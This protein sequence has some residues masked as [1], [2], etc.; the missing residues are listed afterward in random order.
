[1]GWKD[2]EIKLNGKPV[3]V[4]DLQ[5]GTLRVDKSALTRGFIGFYCVRCNFLICAGDAIGHVWLRC[6]DCKSEYTAND[7]H[8]GGKVILMRNSGC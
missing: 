8:I 2:V 7:P 3:G 4:T 1:M 5:Y 6:P